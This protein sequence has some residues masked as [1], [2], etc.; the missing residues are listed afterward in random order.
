MILELREWQ[1]KLW[2]SMETYVCHQSRICRTFLSRN[3]G[4]RVISRA[5]SRSRAKIISAQRGPRIS[6][7]TAII[8]NMTNKKTYV[9]LSSKSHWSTFGLQF[10]NFAKSKKT[11]FKRPNDFSISKRLLKTTFTLILGLVMFLKF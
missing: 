4:P 9:V 3:I 11:N 2:R 8:S 5:F 7:L 10:S 6:G 1:K